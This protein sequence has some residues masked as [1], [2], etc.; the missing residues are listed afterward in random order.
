MPPEVS[1]LYRIVLAILGFLLFHIK[2]STFFSRSG[3]KFPGIL[4][5]IALKL[6]ISFGKIVIFVML[7]LPAHEHGRLESLNFKIVIYL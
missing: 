1:V 2:L 4:M 5:G 6:H 7:F 3:K